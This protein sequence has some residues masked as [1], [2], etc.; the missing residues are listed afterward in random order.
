MSNATPRLVYLSI[1]PWSERARWA[2]DHHGIEY[3]LVAH[4]PVTGERRL[5]RL[6]GAGAGRVTVPVL[7]LPGEVIRESWDIAR[8]ADR[9]GSG[10][11]LIPAERAAEVRQYDDLAD[12]TMASARALVTA[13]LLANP[14]A[15]DETL[16]RD[17]P[18]W[19]RPCLRP[20][21]RHGTRWFARK[22]TLTLGDPAAPTAALRAA[23]TTLRERLAQSSPHL[24]GAFSYADIVMAGLLQGVAPVDDQYI[25]LGPA[26]RAV[27]SQP[28][29]AAEFADLIRWRDALYERQRRPRQERGAAARP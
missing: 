22:Y 7:L 27:W 26:T 23:L 25:R 12:R 28:A 21:V 1:S 18:R 20:L 24:L 6:V 5:R 29:L 15:L 10:T 19:L 2:L 14:A 16:P 4:V 17:V 11:P 9:H 8:Y 13:R 3:E